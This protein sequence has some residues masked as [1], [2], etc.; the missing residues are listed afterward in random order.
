MGNDNLILVDIFDNEIDRT[1]KLEAHSSPMLHRAFSVFLYDGNYMLIQQRALN[2][3]HSAGLWANTCCSHPRTDNLL[4]DATTRL[5]E[6]MNIRCDNLKELFSFTYLT[7]FSDN[8]FEYELDHVVV[9]KYDKNIPVEQNKDEVN[10]VMW[11][12]IDTLA[13]D[14][15]QNPLK[16]TSWFLICAPK[17]IQY[18]KNNK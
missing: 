8:L 10:A 9:G 16:Y 3:Y 5:W 7:Q 18:I 17:V 14:M 12:N 13:L 4:K 1:S 2:K 11:V 6:E 15:Q